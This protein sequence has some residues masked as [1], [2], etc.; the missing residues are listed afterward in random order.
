MKKGDWGKNHRASVHAAIVFVP[1]E[2]VD[3]FDTL[4]LILFTLSIVC[5]QYLVSLVSADFAE[6]FLVN[7]FE[8]RVLV[9]FSELFFLVVGVKRLCT[10]CL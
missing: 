8:H 4:T 7:L 1:Q 2:H 9:G 3:K 10:K 6:V 5:V